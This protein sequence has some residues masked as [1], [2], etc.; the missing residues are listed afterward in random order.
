M[1]LWSYYIQVIISYP[2]I[3]TGH[4]SCTFTEILENIGPPPITEKGAFAIFSFTTVEGI[5]IK[6]RYLKWRGKGMVHRCDHL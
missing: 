1:E 3:Q 5:K 4:N 2:M 6:G